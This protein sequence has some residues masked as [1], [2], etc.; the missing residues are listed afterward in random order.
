[1]AVIVEV[2]DERPAEL[3]G[4]WLINKTR[5]CGYVFENWDVLRRG[6]WEQ[7]ELETEEDRQGHGKGKAELGDMEI[8]SSCVVGT[9]ASWM[10][11][12]VR[13]WIG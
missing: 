13:Q 9:E 1:M 3:D 11:W 4:S 10:Q 5:G 2:C 6:L 8:G 12:H 7:T